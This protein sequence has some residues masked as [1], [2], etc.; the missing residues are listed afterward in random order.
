MAAGVTGRLWDIDDVIKLVEQY[1]AELF[2][3]EKAENRRR[4]EHSYGQIGDVLGGKGL[5]F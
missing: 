1:P 3:E 2:E 4:M 5:G